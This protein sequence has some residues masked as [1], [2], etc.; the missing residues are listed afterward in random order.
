[1]VSTPVG[2]AGIIYHL[3]FITLTMG[4]FSLMS[5]KKPISSGS[6]GGGLPQ[7]QYDHNSRG[8]I[9]PREMSFVKH[10]LVDKLGHRKAEEVMGQLEAHMDNDGR[11][12]GRNVSSKEVESTLKILKKG[13]YNHMDSGD[14]DATRKILEEYQ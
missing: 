9:T 4:L 2:R 8:R 13:R 14:L 5:R 11:L 7:H 12:G 6:L 3:S 10:R 1:M